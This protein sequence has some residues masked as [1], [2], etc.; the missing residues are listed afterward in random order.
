MV[1]ITFQR[2]DYRSP[3]PWVIGVIVVLLLIWL[4]LGRSR[5]P[6]QHP[7]RV[8]SV[9]TGAVATPPAGNAAAPATSASPTTPASPA[10]GP[11]SA[12]ATPAP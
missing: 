12:R 6:V 5:A 2:R 1:D 10:T 9:S 4:L 7:G 8:N 11:G 3:L